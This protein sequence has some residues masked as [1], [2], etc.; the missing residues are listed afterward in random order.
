M[1]IHVVF[2]WTMVFDEASCLG[3]SFTESELG[4]DVYVKTGGMSC[5]AGGGVRFTQCDGPQMG[6]R[7]IANP[8]S[9]NLSVEAD[10]VVPHPLPSELGIFAAT[11]P[12]PTVLDFRMMFD[13]G[14]NI[15]NITVLH[16]HSFVLVASADTSRTG[17]CDVV[18]G[19]SNLFFSM[20][21][22]YLDLLLQMYIGTTST[23]S[24]KMSFYKTSADPLLWVSTRLKLGVDEGWSVSFT[25][26]IGFD[27]TIASVS[28]YLVGSQND[29]IPY[30]LGC[31]NGQS[32]GITLHRFSVN[33]EPAIP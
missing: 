1:I 10:F 16:P 33:Q 11:L 20:S 12:G 15:S 13:Q 18:V 3:G 5:V 4:R 26:L 25:N 30:E 6:G 14:A 24:V 31:R 7:F 29:S 28:K 17:F 9:S 23:F 27:W 2:G 8:F 19:A 22:T 21:Q 32:P